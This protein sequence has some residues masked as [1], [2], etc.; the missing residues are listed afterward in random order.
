MIGYTVPALL[1]VP[2]VIAIELGVLRTGLFRRPAYWISMAIVLGFQIPVD[3]WLTKLSAPI[4]IY[5][6]AHNSGLRWPWDIPVEDFLFGFSLV[7]LVLLLW[8][9][10]RRKAREDARA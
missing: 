4:V 9:R 1:S 8:E 3:G 2:V 7:T 10:Q 5:D 6:P